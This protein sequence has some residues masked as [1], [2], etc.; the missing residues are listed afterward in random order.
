MGSILGTRTR[1]GVHGLTFKYYKLN[2][3]L[4]FVECWTG[5]G[6]DEMDGRV[7]GCQVKL[8]SG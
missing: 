8:G 7:E 5:D 1:S 4:W 3:V 6:W 2:Q